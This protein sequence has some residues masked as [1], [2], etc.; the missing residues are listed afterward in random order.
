MPKAKQKMIRLNSPQAAQEMQDE[1]FRKMS[2]EESIRLSG[3]F[4]QFARILNKLGDD[5][6]GTN[7]TRRIIKQ[8][9]EHSQ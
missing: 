7:G 9:R 1:I 5:Y 4:Y 2:A 6:D 3:K 8:N